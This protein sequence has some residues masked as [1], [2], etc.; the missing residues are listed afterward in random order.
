MSGEEATLRDSV[1]IQCII[2]TV[3]FSKTNK[4]ASEDDLLVFIWIG[5]SISVKSNDRFAGF[6]WKT[7][8]FWLWIPVRIVFRSTRLTTLSIF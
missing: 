2:Y 7:P 5:A 4:E 6:I 8:P 1:K 3:H